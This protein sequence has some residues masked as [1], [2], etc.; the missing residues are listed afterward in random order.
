MSYVTSY[1]IVFH[2][3]QFFIHPVEGGGH[4]GVN[5]IAIHHGR[6]VWHLNPDAV[7]IFRAFQTGSQPAVRWLSRIFSGYSIQR[8][9][10]INHFLLVSRC[11]WVWAIP[12]PLFCAE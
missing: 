8:V 12:T 11:E 9:V 5:S 6:K 1:T 7:D 2:I 4:D 3:L 10:V